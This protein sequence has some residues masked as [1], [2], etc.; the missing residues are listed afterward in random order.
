MQYP[1]NRF[2]RK[3][4]VAH[5]YSDALIH[6]ARTLSSHTGPKVKFCA[7][8][9]ANAYGHG[10]AEVVNILKDGP[11]DFFAVASL[12]E[13]Y[14]IAQMAI[15]Q[16]VLVLEPL[17]PGQDKEQIILAARNSIHCTI[18]SMEAAE[19]VQGVLANTPYI[20]Q[21][22]VNIDSGMGRCGISP[23]DGAKLLEKVNELKKLNLAGIYTHFATADED[24]LSFAY[25]QLKTFN[26]FLDA[27]SLKNRPNLIIHAANSAATIKMPQSHFNMVRCGVSLYG[28]FSRPQAHPQL[29]LRPAMRLEAPIVLIKPMPA[30]S[31][32][33]YGRSF[34]AKR[35]TLV[36]LV[37]LGYADGYWRCF[38]N[39][40]VMKVGEYVAPVIG[41]VCMDQALIDVTDVP[42]V[43][44]GQK[45]TILDNDHDSPCGAYALSQLAET[46]VYEIITCVHEHVDRVIH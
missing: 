12:Y 21:L 7:V 9:K 39:K 3:D 45:A 13:A 38:S 30:G 1:S 20:L 5:I 19:Y 35:D 2:I 44:L 46:I 27:N 16:P 8:V 36:G 31:P 14:Y 42:G 11:V 37:P 18:S 32:I 23:A 40:A 25:E 10:I 41:R 28:Y 6:N 33:S 22:H 29:K 24:D 34:V 43:H 26:A 4:L 15:R 17:H